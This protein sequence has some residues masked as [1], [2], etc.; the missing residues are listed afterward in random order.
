[1]NKIE[2]IIT[3]CFESEEMQAYLIE[4]SSKLTQV[5]AVEIIRGAPIPLIRKTELMFQP[6]K[7]ICV[8][9]R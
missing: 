6:S 2:E 1:M 9:F 4:H 5:Q 7:L 3:V 8:P